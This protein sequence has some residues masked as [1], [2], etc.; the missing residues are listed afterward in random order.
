M[1]QRFYTCGFDTFKNTDNVL[2]GFK[3][4]NWKKEL[5]DADRLDLLVPTVQTT[6]IS[7]AFLIKHSLTI[8]LCV[9]MPAVQES[10]WKWKNYFYNWFG[11]YSYA[12]YCGQSSVTQPTLVYQCV[13]VYGAWQHLEYYPQ[14]LWDLYNEAMLFLAGEGIYVGVLQTWHQMYSNIRYYMR[15]LCTLSLPVC[16][17]KMALLSRGYF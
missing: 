17:T 12:V 6:K 4:W 5:S 8:T 16:V 13:C 14:F 11:L 2:N 10:V 15:C 7:V 3:L 9:S 1:W